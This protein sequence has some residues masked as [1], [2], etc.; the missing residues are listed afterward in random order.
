MRG[1]DGAD[2]RRERREAE[3]RIPLEHKY[4]GDGMAPGNGDGVADTSIV[5]V[6]NLWWATSLAFY[7]G[8][9][10]VGDQHAVR[11]FRDAD[12]DGVF[13]TELPIVAEIPFG[14]H[15]RTRTI[16]FDEINDKLYVSVGS[17]CDLCREENPERAAIL[18][19]NADGTGRRV[20]GE[21]VKVSDVIEA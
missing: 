16:Q 14:D 1:A 10:Y 18:E 4:K 13:E 5:V 3:A 15:H 19:F 7:K 8:D 17:S 2:A 9:L 12:G 21:L 11:R 6:D 20:L